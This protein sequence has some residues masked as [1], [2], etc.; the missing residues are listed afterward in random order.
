MIKTYSSRSTLVGHNGSRQL[1][2]AGEGV[3]R[4][5][6]LVVQDGQV[7]QIQLNVHFFFMYLCV[8]VIYVILNYNESDLS[9]F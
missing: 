3:R 9:Q 5:A 7:F 8:Y 6:L 2:V 4:W 1:L